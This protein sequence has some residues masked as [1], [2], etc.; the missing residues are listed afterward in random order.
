MWVC[1]LGVAV[2]RNAQLEPLQK[3]LLFQWSRVLSWAFDTL[4]ELV[5]L[6]G[7]CELRLWFKLGW[8]SSY[9]LC[10][11]SQG[12]LSVFA[13]ELS[14]FMDQCTKPTGTKLGLPQCAGLEP[15][16]IQ[17]LFESGLLILGQ[18]PGRWM[19]QLPGGR[20]LYVVLR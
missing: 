16:L 20:N 12:Q 7:D 2:D 4:T 5:A 18:E 19:E 6:L 15:A 3:E 14:Q 10:P 1:S 13:P 17:L 8:T 9:F 11:S